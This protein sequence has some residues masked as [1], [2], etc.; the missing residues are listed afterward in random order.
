MAMPFV[1]FPPATAVTVTAVTI[2]TANVGLKFWN[3]NNI[4]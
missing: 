4:K 3:N 1:L 2:A